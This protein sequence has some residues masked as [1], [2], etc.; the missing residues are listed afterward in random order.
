[1]DFLTELENMAINIGSD[2]AHDLQL[3]DSVITRW[4]QLFRYTR[5]D[6]ISRIEN[7][8]SD[9]SRRRVSD[10]H[11][12]M[13]HCAKEADGYDREA[14]EHEVELG[15]TKYAAPAIPGKALLTGN[16]GRPE[17]AVQYRLVHR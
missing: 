13:V 10:E 4:Q 17:H 7:H 16:I 14:Y 3:S 15:R 2:A 9:I 5:A 12:D 6:A 8:R 11:W 1:M